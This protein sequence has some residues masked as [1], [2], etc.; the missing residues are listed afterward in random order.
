MLIRRL[1]INKSNADPTYCRSS[2]SARFVRRVEGQIGV[3]PK[4]QT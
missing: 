3:R 4:C 1:R 2:K